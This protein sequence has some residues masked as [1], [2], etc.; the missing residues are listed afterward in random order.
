[1][2]V[3]G[4]VSVNH[5]VVLVQEEEQWLFLSRKSSL[6]KRSLKHLVDE[7]QCLQSDAANHHITGQ[8]SREKYSLCVKRKLQ[9][10]FSFNLFIKIKELNYLLRKF[11]GRCYNIMHVHLPGFLGI[12]VHVQRQVVYFSEGTLIWAKEA[13]NMSD[14]SDL[15]IV[16]RGSELIT[17]ISIDWLYQR[18]YFIMDELVSLR[19]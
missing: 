6:R 1:M 5:V 4:V 15:R 8:Y 3:V 13:S 11:F 12:S 16:Y 19:V 9:V 14:V 18:M 2:Y 17:S 7:A 10:E